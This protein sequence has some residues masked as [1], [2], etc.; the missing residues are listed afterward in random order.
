MTL[1]IQPAAEF[2]FTILIDL[3]NRAFKG[4][5][6]GD[7]HFTP[8]SFA[9]LLA[10]DGVDL[11][12]SAVAL[13]DDQPIGFALIARRGASSRVAAFGIVPE[14]QE[15]G[16][17]KIFMEQVIA[18]ARARADREMVLESFEQ[19]TRA[20]RLYRSLGFE[21]LRRLMGYE[22]TNLA[23]TPA[24]LQ[25]VDVTEMARHQLGWQPDDLAWQCSGEALMKFGPPYVTYR[26]D[27]SYILITDPSAERIVV[28]GLAVPPDQQRQG[29]ATRML[30]AVLAAHP[31]KAWFVPQ[32]CP[33]E[34]GS[35]FLRNGFQPLPLN[36][37]QMRLR[38]D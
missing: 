31:G 12:L 30:A 26:M 19:N 13:R 22:G 35:I 15:K 24:S 23:G 6:A 5:I 10:R 32:I 4:Y 25:A 28:R 9:A 38:L 34:I 33:E 8:H 20:V 36:Q 37:F 7:A 1:R 29:K 11:A 14:A 3:F 17:G 27:D 18:Q 16:A 21:P 2:P